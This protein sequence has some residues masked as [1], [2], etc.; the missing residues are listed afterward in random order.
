[1]IFRPSDLISR[2]LICAVLLL[3]GGCMTHEEG[4]F[5]GG[6]P[7]IVYDPGFVVDQVTMQFD[8]SKPGVDWGM[9]LIWQGD[10][11][12][13]SADQN[14]TPGKLTQTWQ[15]VAIQQI[16]LLRKGQMIALGTCRVSGKPDSR[17]VAIVDYRSDERWLD[18]FEGAW[19][20]DYSKDAFEPVPTGTLKCINW[21]YGLGLDKPPAAA[22][23]PA[24]AT[25][26]APPH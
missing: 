16:P 7:M 14:T 13:V 8:E 5:V 3:L 20:Y 26:T 15:V 9:S 25:Y 6:N 22:T 4:L 19:A 24:A 1:M 18:H 21:R 10:H 23:T 11:Y 17:V 2:S 12:I